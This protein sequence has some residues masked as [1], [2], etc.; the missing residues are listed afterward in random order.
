M[1]IVD[2]ITGTG[3]VV[4]FV[5]FLLVLA[6][7]ISWTIIFSKLS[8]FRVLRKD[9]DKFLEKFWKG[10]SLDAIYRDTS[11]LNQSPL[12]NIFRSAYQ[13]FAKVSSKK[14]AEKDGGVEDLLHIG[15]DNVERVLKKS[16]IN[17]AL[18]VE[19][20]LIYL[21]MIANAA[22][23][24]G[25]FGTVWGIMDAFLQ[26]G[27]GG[28]S[29]LD[30]VGPGIAEALVATAVGLAAAIPASLFYNSFLSRAKIARVEME[31]FCIDFVNILKRSTIN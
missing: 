9:T 11:E 12:S 29:T 26:M 8:V 27:Q 19:S 13:E 30:K 15:M 3:L 7:I 10:K 14:D 31:S 4:K 22:P 21:A 24:I 16:A 23:F 25:L 6:S 5:L 20:L 2:I 18:R 28:G 17:E 1:S